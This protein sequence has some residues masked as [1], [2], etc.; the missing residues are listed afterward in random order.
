LSRRASS[1]EWREAPATSS[2]TEATAPICGSGGGAPGELLNPPDQRIA[3]EANVVF[4]LFDEAARRSDLA[5]AHQRRRKR[6]VFVHHRAG[7]QREPARRIR[8]PPPLS[9][10]LDYAEQRPD[11][12]AEPRGHGSHG[13]QFDGEGRVPCAVF[14][15]FLGTRDKPRMAAE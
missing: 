12:R 10:S 6:Q 2:R 4:D 1:G 8:Q 3:F 15:R 9:S 11:G 13:G 7:A 14:A 5:R